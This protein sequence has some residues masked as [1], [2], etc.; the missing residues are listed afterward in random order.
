MM[1]ES[2]FW[3]VI[4]NAWATTPAL[5][6]FQQ[7][8]LGTMASQAKKTAFEEKYAEVEPYIPDEQVF[9]QA[10][11]DQLDTLS[12]EDLLAFDRILERKLY[13]IDR[14]DVHRYT[15]GSDD[16]FLYCRGFIVAMG[17]TFYNAVDNTPSHAMFDWDCEALTYISS[18]VYE[19]KFGEIPCSDISR[20]SF[21][22]ASGWQMD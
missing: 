2:Q 12:A 7:E 5:Q 17:E 20:E 10:I 15:D 9:I 8:V 21:S 16:G 6:A 22:N 1:N 13:D 19:E 4:E 18:H 11:N 14:K 3:T